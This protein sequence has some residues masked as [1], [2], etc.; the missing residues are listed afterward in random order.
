VIGAGSTFQS[1]T[2]D[3]WL[4]G[5]FLN[6]A[7]SANPLIAT[8]G[9]TLD[10]DLWQHESG[11]VCTPFEPDPDYGSTLEKCQRYYTQTYDD[12][13]GNFAGNT[14]DNNSVMVTSPQTALIPGAVFPV[15]MR[16]AP[17]V[18]IYNP[19]SGAQNSVRISGGSNIAVNS[20]VAGRKAIAN[21]TL[22]S[23]LGTGWAQYH[24]TASA[25]L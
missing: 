3:S 4:T 24:Y 23:A 22:N 10:I 15:S 18:T 20:L 16:V 14:G 7:A 1:A 5:N 19:V 12:L 25:E 8:N 6:T 9:A 21:I 11:A 17:A 2:Q 13:A